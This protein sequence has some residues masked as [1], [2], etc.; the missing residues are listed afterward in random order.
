MNNL[1]LTQHLNYQVSLSMQKLST[2]KI[3]KLA[4]IF[5][6]TS[7]ISPLA[8]ASDMTGALSA[9]YFIW[10]V[11]PYSILH[12]IVTIY[13]QIKNWGKP[14]NKR[15][16]SSYQLANQHLYGAYGIV[17]IGFMLMSLDYL[18]SLGFTV[19]R[20]GLDFILTATVY[21]MVVIAIAYIPRVVSRFDPPK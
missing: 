18:F 21:Y 16:F 2:K 15:K 17:I 1:L 3:I 6:L 12:F 5:T 13:Q 14:N 4:S 19:N 7:S 20:H 9:F 8:F 10:V 11:I